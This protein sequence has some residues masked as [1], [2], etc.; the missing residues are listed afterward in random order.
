MAEDHGILAWLEGAAHASV[1]AALCGSGFRK[2]FVS[3]E[4]RPWQVR[5]ARIADLSGVIS[6]ILSDR[7]GSRQG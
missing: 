5:Q 7:P 2:T 4:Q 3:M 6:R 1:V